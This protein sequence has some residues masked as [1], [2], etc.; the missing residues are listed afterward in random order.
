MMKRRSGSSSP[1]ECRPR[2][3]EPS[4]SMRASAAAPMR[5]MMRML[6]TTY[7]ESVIS[8]PQRDSGESI[9]PMQYGM[10]YI[11]RPRMQPSNNASILACASEG[12]IQW[13]FGP[14]SSR[15]VVHTKVRCS[16]RATSS[17]CER[18]SQLRGCVCSFNGSS[19]PSDSICFTSSANS[20]SLPSHHWMRSGWVSLATSMTHWFNASSWLPIA[21]F[22]TSK[23]DSVSGARNER[24]HHVLHVGL[25]LL[26]LHVHLVQ[27]QV[28]LEEAHVGGIQQPRAMLRIGAAQA[29]LAERRGEIVQAALGHAHDHRLHGGV[30]H[31][32]EQLG[33]DDVRLGFVRD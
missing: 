12:A 28:E 9:G 20:V 27:L 3:K 4:R 25:E 16:T 8:T 33:I 11:V 7:G 5:V 21:V 2:T 6:A 19:V 29:G 23:G 22:S 1:I 10:T 14:A 15:C 31:R 18:C 17:G 13:L 24:L 32:L 30:V 26:V